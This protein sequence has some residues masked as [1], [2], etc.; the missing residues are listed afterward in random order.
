MP[1]P[2][3]R[4]TLRD[5]AAELGV[6]AKTVSNAYARPD[7]LSGELRERVLATA[8]RLGYPGPDPVAAG[9]RR[10]RVGA[11]GF[12]YDNQLSYAFDDPASSALLAGVAATVEEAGAGLLLLPGSSDR[13]RRNAAV[14]GAVV[15]GLLISSVADD[16]PLLQA[17]APP[18]SATGG[19]RSAA[20]GPA[21]AAG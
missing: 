18:S 8:A 20:T 10:G 17:R 7:Q 14:T 11:I 4:L 12:A 5:V 21:S 1:S 6:S 3:R 15:D 19:H 16:D 2:A 9:L 13:Q